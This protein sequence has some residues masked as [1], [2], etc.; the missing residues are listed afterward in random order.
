MW[1]LI[2]IFSI[3]EKLIETSGDVT[4]VNDKLSGLHLSA[5]ILSN[6]PPDSKG[7][8]FNIKIFTYHTTN[9]WTLL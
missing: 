1:N 9:K 8:V 2:D 7:W 3:V 4:A 5:V 6:A